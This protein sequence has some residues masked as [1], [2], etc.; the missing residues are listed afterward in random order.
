[1]IIKIPR[2]GIEYNFNKPVYNITLKNPGKVNILINGKTKEDGIVINPNIL[3]TVGFSGIE[4]IYFIPES[5]TNED[6]EEIEVV[7]IE[8][9]K[10]IFRGTVETKEKL[11]DFQG[12][13]N[14]VVI[15]NTSGND[16]YISVNKKID[17]DITYSY[18]IKS[19]EFIEIEQ[20]IEKLYLL[21][22]GTSTYEIYAYKKPG[23]PMMY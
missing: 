6:F 10:S 16:F 20:N 1:M 2:D 18:K 11:I 15:K 12:N 7:S 9:L 17:N 8:Y 23:I 5:I 19:N 3:K 14:G 21:S 13:A 4:K 22:E